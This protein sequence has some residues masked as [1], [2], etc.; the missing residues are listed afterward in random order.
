MRDKPAT[1]NQAKNSDKSSLPPKFWVASSADK[2]GGQK[3][4]FKNKNNATGHV[5]HDLIGHA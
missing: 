1:G 4:A 3:L 2:R 5:L